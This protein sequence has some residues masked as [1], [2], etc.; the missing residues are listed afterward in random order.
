[1]L[2]LLPRLQKGNERKVGSRLT[3]KRK[4][5]KLLTRVHE[6]SEQAAT[7]TG[8]MTPLMLLGENL[9]V[10]RIRGSGRAREQGIT[11]LAG[12]ACGNGIEESKFPFGR[13]CCPSAFE[14]RSK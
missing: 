7:C 5:A 6:A 8:L 4:A 10:L 13:D 1:M 9:W 14:Y 11:L 12:L 3:R 2:C